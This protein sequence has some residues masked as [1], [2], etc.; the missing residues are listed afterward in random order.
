MSK[1]RKLHRGERFATQA[2]KK[3]GVVDTG[4]DHREGAYSFSLFAC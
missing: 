1:K 3:D 2:P 4:M